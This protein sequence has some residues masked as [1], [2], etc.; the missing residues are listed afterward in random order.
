MC[1]GRTLVQFVIRGV[2]TGVYIG[3]YTP[4]PKKSAQVNFLWGKSD[5]RTAIRQFYTPPQKKTNKFLATPLSLMCM[6]FW[7]IGI[8]NWP[9]QLNIQFS[10]GS[11]AT[12]FRWSG[13]LISTFSAVHPRMPYSERIIK[14]GPFCESYEALSCVPGFLGHSVENF[15]F[16]CVK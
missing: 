15:A 1:V 3:I 2:A 12:N 11:A 16:L 4:S 10:R 14:I 8:N 6:L 9:V 5:V 13:N 7:L